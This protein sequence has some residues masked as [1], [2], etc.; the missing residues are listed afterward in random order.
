MLGFESADHPLGPWLDRALECCADHG[1]APRDEP[2]LS[3]PDDEGGR[4]PVGAAGEGAGAW[5]AAFL[6]A[7]Y[8]R[9]TMVAAGILSETFETAITWDR[10]E[11]FVAGVRE[12]AGAALRDTYG[13]GSITCRLT[14][15]YPDG[16]APYFTLLAPARRGSELEQWAEVKAAASEAVLDAGG[17]ITHHHAVGPRPPALVRPSAPGAVRAGAARRQGGRGPRRDAQSRRA[18]GPRR[19]RIASATRRGSTR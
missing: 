5:R 16:A 11:E 3:G 6:Q 19:L 18:R 14:H 17:T 15:V 9:D 13:A 12:R 7:P 8:L 1:G 2:R 4:N 10:F